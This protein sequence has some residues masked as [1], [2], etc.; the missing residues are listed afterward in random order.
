[1]HQ[2]ARIALFLSLFT[3]SALATRAQVVFSP[4]KDI[5][6][7]SAGTQFQ[8]IA[9]DASGNINVAWLDSSPGPLA[10]AVFYSR[11]SDGG[12]T[13]STPLTI[14]HSGSG[15]FNPGIAAGPNG[16]VYIIW[17]ERSP[18]SSSIG[19]FFSRSIDGGTTFSA[20]QAISNAGA[21]ARLGQMIVDA[22][23]NIHVLWTDNSPGNYAGFF[24]HSSDGGATFSAPLNLSNDTTVSSFNP[25]AQ[26]AGDS[27]GA[28][29]VVWTENGGPFTAPFASLLFSRS[30]DGGNTF[31][32]PLTLDTQT[33]DP[34]HPVGMPASGLAVDAN[35]N[36]NL[37][38]SR[39]RFN[40]DWNE[41]DVRFAHSSDRG[42]TFSSP[43]QISGNAGGNRSPQMALGP[44]GDINVAYY[45]N[46]F[47]P[48]FFNFGITD[49]LT[50][51]I[52]GGATFPSAWNSNSCGDAS[53]AQIRIDASGK[54]DLIYGFA[55]GSNCATSTSG[56][57]FTRSADGSTFS[58]P[59]K[60]GD[61]SLPVMA[62]DPSGSIYVAWQ[63]FVNRHTDIFFS[64]SVALASVAASPADLT[65]GGSSTGTVAMNGPAPTGG[66]VVSLSS[67]DSSVSVPATV[68]IAEGTTSA[69][70]A[71]TTNPVA[72]A[73]ASTISAV[74]SG[75]TQ[76]ASI[77]VEPPVLTAL[78]LSS[79]SVQGGNSATGTVT[80][81][82]PS[83]AG[84]SVVALSSSNTSAA[85][86]PAS[87]TVMPGFI[88]VSFTVGTS[89]EL[90]PKAATISASFS[91]VTQTSNLAIQPFVNLPPQACAAINPH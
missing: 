78:A 69:T 17:I 91:G 30:V 49:T 84:G 8:Q 50:R 20:P 63:G 53:A 6:N 54:I 58:S 86:V 16:N 25:N 60:I 26:I 87:V 35:G 4:P 32:T 73:T 62:L 38:W 67:S 7:S 24:S 11:S 33:G 55:P 65:G 14:S 28:I 77:T 5:S 42:A 46:P 36:I 43:V 9:V 66:A 34:F 79:S 21:D 81:S 47:F 48:Q 68:T 13:F 18:G 31:S 29:N 12:L 10:A 76:T 70:F 3:V 27:S 88:N 80:L 19:V 2:S 82:G 71:V 89:R 40:G 39:S 15:A 74:F 57:F 41:L 44:G 56:L 1:L 61:G 37:L 45:T 52:D 72:T 85:M 75:V 59:Q 51:S 83:P 64:R 22:R 23:G 90:C